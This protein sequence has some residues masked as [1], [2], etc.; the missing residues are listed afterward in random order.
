[1]FANQF[2]TMAQRVSS[3]NDPLLRDIDV[4]AIL[5]VSPRTL[6]GWRLVGIGP[7]FV[8]MGRVVRYKRQDLTAW[9]DASTVSATSRPGG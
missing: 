6:Q 7:P 8:K 9:I 2:A 4:A 3:P 5:C 1:M